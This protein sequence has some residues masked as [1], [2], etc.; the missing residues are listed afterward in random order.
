MI[1]A[2]KSSNPDRAL[3]CYHHASAQKPELHNQWM[4]SI[5]IL[6]KRQYDVS[7]WTTRID[8]KFYCKNIRAVSRFV[9]SQ[10]ETVLLCNDV[11]HWLGASLEST[12]HMNV[13]Y[14]CNAE[15]FKCPVQVY[16]QCWN[17]VSVRTNHSSGRLRR[18]KTAQGRVKLTHQSS[19]RTSAN[20]VLKKT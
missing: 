15:I 5:I 14:Q 2:W 13:S 11:S 12:L 18:V 1:A 16:C 9:P 20:F 7:I 6:H 8:V 3:M 17:N 19:D 10:W 4:G